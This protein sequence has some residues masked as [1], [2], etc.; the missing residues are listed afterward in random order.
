[1]QP[2]PGNAFLLSA[3][4]R[5]PG[6]PTTSCS[7]SSFRYHPTHLLPV[8]HYNTVKEDKG[9][10]DAANARTHTHTL[11]H[12]YTLSHTHSHTLTHT[13]THTRTHAHTHTHRA[14]NVKLY[15]KIR[16]LQSYSGSQTA[17]QRTRGGGGGPDHVLNKSVE[18]SHD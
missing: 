7:I 15:E 12:S 13:H 9:G 11:T 17:A 1:M 10:V 5:G 8:E 4:Q 18:V 16:Y 14:D 3:A 6:T 2:C